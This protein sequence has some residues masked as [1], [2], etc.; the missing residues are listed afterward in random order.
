MLPVNINPNPVYLATGATDMRKSING[1]AQEVYSYFEA[2]LFSGS[3]FAFCNKR[4]KIVKLLYW[5]GTGF[6]LWMKRLDKNRFTRVRQ[7]ICR[8][9]PRT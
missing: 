1:L 4:K 9:Q 8:Y 3:I 6:C 2:D 7:P 5:D